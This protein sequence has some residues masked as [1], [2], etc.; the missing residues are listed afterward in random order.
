MVLEGKENLENKTWDS[1]PAKLKSQWNY[2]KKSSRLKKH[3]GNLFTKNVQLKV[4]R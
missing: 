3:K 2:K 1:L 4:P